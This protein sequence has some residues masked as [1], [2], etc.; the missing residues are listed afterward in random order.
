LYLLKALKKPIYK[1]LGFKVVLYQKKICNQ[2]QF[3][4]VK[5][6]IIELSHQLY[7]QTSYWLLN[8]DFEPF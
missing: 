3:Y 8:G 5:F 1:F 6:G 2:N 4:G 7:Q